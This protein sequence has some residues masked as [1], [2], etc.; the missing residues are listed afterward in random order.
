MTNYASHFS[1]LKTPQTER[2]ERHQVRNSAGGYTFEI[3]PMQRLDRWLILGAEGGTYY[4]SE[5]KLTV[6]NAKTV[7][8]CLDKDGPGTVRRI[9]EIS[10]SGRAPKNDPA[11][12]ALAIAASHKDEA[13]RREALAALPSVCRTGTHLFTFVEA[14]KSFRGWG[15]GLRKAVASWYSSKKADQLAYQVLKYQNRNGWSHADVLRLCHAELPSTHDPIARW[16]LGADTK[17][18]IV[19]RGEKSFV[20]FGTAALPALLEAYAELKQATDVKTVVSLI[21]KHGFTHEMVPNQWKN[22]VGVWDALSLK[23][24]IG[25][26]VRNLAKMTNVGLLKPM[27]IPTNRVVEQLTSVEALKKGRMHPIQLLSALKTYSQGHGEKG[28]LT[29]T[30]LREVVDALDE[31]FYMS[32]GALEPTGKRIVLAL[33]VSGS[34]ASGPIAGI[35]GLAPRDV[36]AAMAMVTAR[37]EK[38]WAVM[39]FSNRFIDLKISPRQRLD[40]VI[41]TISG[42]PFEATDCSLPMLWAAGES[43]TADAFCIY[44]DNET[45]AG[46][47][48]PHQALQAYRNKQSVSAKLIVAGTTATGFSI[49]NPA[50][51]GMLDIV[52][53]DS[54]APS[55]ISDFIRT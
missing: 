55:I 19:K 32:F 10:D 16:I 36:T 46:R 29:W 49:A 24:P 22:E 52:G 1:T 40:D 47:V 33:D 27:S 25:A 14:V 17:E 21:L 37:T 39:G 30:P 2:A 35:P 31:A 13:T 20:Y 11:I 51:P 48:H 43:I 18:R 23:M 45:Y 54:A 6:E 7:I 4:A 15:R 5:K 26:T 41:R 38:N 44:T 50:D 3:S 28:K 42:L 34:M 12:F 53:F 8:E 9:V